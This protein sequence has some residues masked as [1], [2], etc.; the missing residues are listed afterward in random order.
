MKNGTRKGKKLTRGKGKI[1]FCTKCGNKLKEGAKFCTSC[2]NQVKAKSLS[3]VNL[4]A[5]K[6]VSVAINEDILSQNGQ[7]TTQPEVQ[8]KM[9][10]E[11]KL[12]T[13]SEEQLVAQSEVPVAAPINFSMGEQ[14]ERQRVAESSVQQQ[15]TNHVLQRS[16]EPTLVQPQINA[17]STVNYQGTP[18]YYHEIP[19][20]GRQEKRGVL[21]QSFQIAAIV[22]VILAAAGTAFWFLGGKEILQ[23]LA[24]GSNTIAAESR[25]RDVD[26]E[27]NEKEIDEENANEEKSVRDRKVQKEDEVDQNMEQEEPQEVEEMQELTE[28]E[29]EAARK[30]TNSMY[31]QIFS[32]DYLI[33]GSDSRYITKDDL[34]YFDAELCRIA[35]NEIYARHGRMFDDEFLQYIFGNRDWYV[36]TIRPSDFKESM[37]NKYEIANRDFIVAYEKEMGFR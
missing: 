23:N 27:K 34:K 11:V 32:Q 9:H 5:T 10:P 29:L 15:A 6:E 17:S 14:T 3:D 1:M 18:N 4:T 22:L 25:E 31:L 2:G 19:N 12:A 7:P 37:L 24:G 33:P 28:E 20:A 8:L 30:D 36:G 16:E 35:R 26:D 13:Q 21:A